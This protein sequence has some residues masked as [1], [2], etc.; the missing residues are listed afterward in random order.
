M[1]YFDLLTH[2]AVTS[3]EYI[4]P[5]TTMTGITS[6]SARKKTAWVQP[7]LDFMATDHHRPGNVP[8]PDVIE[9]FLRACPGPPMAIRALRLVAYRPIKG[10]SGLDPEDSTHVWRGSGH[11][12]TES[13]PMRTLSNVAKGVFCTPD[14]LSK[15]ARRYGYSIALAIRWINFLQGCVLRE[16]G[17]SHECIARR[18]GFSDASSWSRF[19][20]TL[21]GK[22][23][24][25]LPNLMIDDWVNEARRRVF[26]VSFL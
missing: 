12:G 14:H 10:I 24:T 17:M 1:S 26:L 4:G 2:N 7:R 18:L 21:T 15:Q 11:D 16:Q 23:P 22:T 3:N 19:V 20:K 13:A 8:F 25:Q 6:A 9:P 5:Q